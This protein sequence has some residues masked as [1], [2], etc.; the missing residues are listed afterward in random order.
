MVNVPSARK[1]GFRL[2]LHEG[3]MRDV[4]N[5]QAVKGL[6]SEQGDLAAVIVADHVRWVASADDAAS[7]VGAMFTRDTD[8]DAL[9][10]D[11]DGEYELG[12]RPATIV[13]IHSTG[14][15]GNR[16][17]VSSVPGAKPPLMVEA[18]TH[19]LSSVPGFTVGKAGKGDI[20]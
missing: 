8:S 12:N 6:V 2:E 19:S 5:S 16:H 4:L 11:F 10:M 1:L 9:G 7:Y 13:G 17:S 14:T 3:V 15:R 20:R 18:E